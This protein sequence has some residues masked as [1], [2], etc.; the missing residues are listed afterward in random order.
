MKKNLPEDF[1]K[2]TDQI[3]TAYGQVANWAMTKSNHYLPNALSEFL[4]AN[5]ADAWL[6][7]YSLEDVG[8]RIIVTHEKSQPEVKKKIKIPEA[9]APFKINFVDTIEMFRQL[10]ERF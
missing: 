1:F 8:N 6:V 3:F 5:E 4:D 7:A 10:G 2:D 9:C